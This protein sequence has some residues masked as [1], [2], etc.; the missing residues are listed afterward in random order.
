MDLS[1]VLPCFNEEENIKCL[2]E[3]FIQIPLANYKSELILVNNGS[4]DNTGLEIDKIIN[5]NNSKK[6]T[7]F[8]LKK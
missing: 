6:K 1:L 5:I 7:I 3:E 4:S 8:P 2:Y